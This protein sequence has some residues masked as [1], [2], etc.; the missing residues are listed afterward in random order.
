MS[1]G[2]KTIVQTEYVFVGRI[3]GNLLLFVDS[4]N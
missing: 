3:V 2:G 4:G 1:S